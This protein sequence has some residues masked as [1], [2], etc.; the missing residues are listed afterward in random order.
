MDFA[1]KCV[2]GIFMLSMLSSGVGFSLNDAGKYLITHHENF[3]ILRARDMVDWGINLMIIG[4]V[5]MF[6][7][8]LFLIHI[9]ST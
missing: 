1:A 4:V 2:T 5:V 8:G 3:D 7:S 9:L 6:I